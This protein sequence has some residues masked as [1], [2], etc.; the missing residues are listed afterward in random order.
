MGVFHYK[1]SLLP[2]AYFGHEMPA[3]LPETEIERRVWWA[4]QAPTERL[5]SALRTLLP[6][7][8]S[9]GETEEYVSEGDFSSDVRIWKDA[10]R[11][12]GIEFRFSPVCDTW[13]L[14]QQFIRIARDEQCVLLEDESRVVLN[15]DE[16]VVRERFAHSRAAEFLRNPSGTIVRAARKLGNDAG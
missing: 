9:W 4:A 3:S 13:S 15:A 5:L 1:L 6:H 14:V 16:D 11:V 8:K 12:D 7:D 10:G 2:R